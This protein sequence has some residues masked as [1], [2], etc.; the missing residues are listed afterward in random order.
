MNYDTTGLTRAG[1]DLVPPF[2]LDVRLE[3]VVVDL[4]DSETT[5]LDESITPLEFCSVDRVLPGRRLSGLVQDLSGERY[6]AKIFYGR[7]A[8]RYWRREIA[9]ATALSRTEVSSPAHISNG[10]TADGE[11]YVVLYEALKDP[12]PPE[13]EDFA[14]VSAVTKALAGL[15]ES[16]LVHNDP[17]VDNFLF[18]NGQ[19]HVVDADA[20]RIVRKL[21]AQI[22]NLAEFFAQRPPVTDTDIEALWL[23]YLSQ[24]DE[25][26][27]RMVDL[28]QIKALTKKARSRRISRYLKKT[29]RSCTEFVQRKTWSRSFLC[30]RQHW[31]HLQ[32]FLWFPEVMFGEGTPLKLGN[33]ATVVR[34][35]VSGQAYIVKRYNVKGFGHRVKR[36]FKRRA[37]HAWINGH[38]LDFLQIP[39]AKPVALLELKWGWFNGVAYLI[40]PDLGEH[41]LLDVLAA[42]REQSPDAEPGSH[43]FAQ[44]V[45]ILQALRAAGLQHGD[46]KGTN[47][48]TT[49]QRLALIDYDA[50]VKIK[51]A[52]VL[53]G[54]VRSP[55]SQR[56]LRNFVDQPRLMQRWE[57]KFKESAL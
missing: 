28:A 48:V 8:R 30:Q 38:L 45:A 36:W 13:F 20:V 40:M 18:S 52:D 24:R 50:V 35:E 14:Q 31:P 29:Q 47:L 56:F 22:E 17:H 21:Q 4:A 26:V 43:W 53:N 55:D 19:L 41:S 15:H 12:L 32:R 1:V 49:G 57:E 5:V 37:R 7:Q 34:I 16:H 33:S 9:G 44:V 54:T 2:T 25:Y 3:P 11:G 46:L 10:A 42:E 51:D 6:F 23:E 27:A 39:T